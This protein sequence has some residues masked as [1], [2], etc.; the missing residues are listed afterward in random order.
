MEQHDVTLWVSFTECGSLS[1]S[2]RYAFHSPYSYTLAVPRRSSCTSVV[3]TVECAHKACPNQ[4]A[5]E[6]A[7]FYTVNAAVSRPFHYAKYQEDSC[8]HNNRDANRSTYCTPIYSSFCG[9]L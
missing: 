5:I 6:Y 3:P 9:I 4:T 8:S 7:Y 2:I 1:G